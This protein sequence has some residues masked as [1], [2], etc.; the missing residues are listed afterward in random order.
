MGTNRMMGSPVLPAL[1]ADIA[2]IIVFVALGR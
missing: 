2:S 1:A